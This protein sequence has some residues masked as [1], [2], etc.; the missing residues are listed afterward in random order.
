[1]QARDHLCSLRVGAMVGG[2]SAPDFTMLDTV[3]TD[4][5]KYLA[6]VVKRIIPGHRVSCTGGFSEGPAVKRW[7]SALVVFSTKTL[8]SVVIK[9]HLI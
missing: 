4:M 6:S 2:G 7:L 1:M 8:E 3:D 9:S 5:S